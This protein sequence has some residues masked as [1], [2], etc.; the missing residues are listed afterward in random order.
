MKP[1]V[2]SISLNPA[3]TWVRPRAMSSGSFNSRRRGAITGSYGR[4]GQ[5]VVIA[6]RPVDCGLRVGAV[7]LL[8]CTGARRGEFGAARR[9]GAVAGAGRRRSPRL[10]DA[11]D[12]TKGIEEA[13][14]DEVEREVRLQ[15]S[16]AVQERAAS[17][18]A[19][20]DLSA[21]EVREL[22]STKP[23]GQAGRPHQG[24]TLCFS[25][26]G[27]QVTKYPCGEFVGTRIRRTPRK[28]A[29]VFP[30]R[31]GVDRCTLAG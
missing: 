2:N 17:R 3:L 22:L 30:I 16:E 10:P 24:E 26:P 14:R 13:E 12:V 6:A 18:L 1:S 4:G 5:V 20:A 27:L 19:Y 21:A 7:G 29:L 9:N 25:A 11:E 15:S 23:V 8:G 31:S 28:R